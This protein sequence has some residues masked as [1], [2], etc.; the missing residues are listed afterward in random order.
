MSKLLGFFAGV[1]LGTAGAWW[2]LQPQ[3]AQKVNAIKKDISVKSGD[4]KHKAEDL[5]EALKHRATDVQ[6]NL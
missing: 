3:N 1:G 2:F 5:G 6:Q 4:I